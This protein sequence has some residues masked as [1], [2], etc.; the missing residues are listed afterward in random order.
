ML[1]LITTVWT[2]FFTRR[3]IFKIKQQHSSSSESRHNDKHVYMRRIK[4]L[5]GV[6]GMM[7]A[8]TI[9]TFLPGLLVVTIEAVV[10]GNRQS[11]TIF[12]IVLVLYLIN[13]V[14]NPIIQSYFR[15]D[16]YDFLVHCY[17][18]LKTKCTYN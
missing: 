7:L 4:K 15:R 12:T 2:F 6:F 11:T 17:E 8:G 9:L 1:I 16:V 10:G 18:V 14:L 5:V 13:S 3:V